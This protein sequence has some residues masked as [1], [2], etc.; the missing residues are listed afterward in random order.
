MRGSLYSH[1]CRCTKTWRYFTRL[2]DLGRLAA[3]AIAAADTVAQVFSE[4]AGLHQ[5]AM[6]FIKVSM[7][8]ERAMYVA[9]E[10]LRRL[11]P[12]RLVS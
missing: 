1:Y 8:S 7:G 6:T 5:G 2:N 9:H 11:L 4:L 3:D 10:G 12:V